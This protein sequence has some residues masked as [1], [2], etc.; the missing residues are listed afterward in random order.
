M[1][2]NHEKLRM[3]MIIALFAA[4]IGVFSQIIIP[5]PLV[6]ITGQTLAIGL[7]ATILGSRYGTYSVLLYL[8]IGAAGVPVFAGM[9]GGIAKLV[10]PTGGYLFS[11]ILSAFVIGLILEKT[12]Y[13][14]LNAF[15]ANIIGTIINL[16]IGT[17]WLKY[18]AA[19]TWTAAFAS[20]CLPFIIVGILK[21]FLAGWIGI[22]IRNR[23][24]SANMLPKNKIT[25]S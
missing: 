14:L 6:P 11:F 24:S 9:S 1:N 10:G 19:L 18:A 15:W 20:G 23:L 4:L 7:A 21:A 3:M 17:I 22:L 8:F 13:S 12:R 25:I 16:V 2:S 5:I